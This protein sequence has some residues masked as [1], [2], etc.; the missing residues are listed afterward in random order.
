MRAVALSFVLALAQTGFAASPNPPPPASPIV[1]PEREGLELAT[2]LRST[3]P[4]ESSEFTGVLE[5]T[6]RDGSI[7]SVPVLSKLTV[8][9][10]NWLVVYQSGPTNQTPSETLTITHTPG[11]PNAYA[12]AIGTNPPASTGAITSPFGR[13]DFWLIDLGLDFLHW[14]KQRAIRAEMTRSRPCRVLESAH[15]NP[16]AGAYSRVLSWVDLETGGI[17]QAEAYDAQNKLLKK[18]AIGPVRKV[19]GQWQ[20]REMRIRNVQTRQQTELKFD[21]SGR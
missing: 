11:Q 18:F 1:D 17:I 14:P 3:V 2:R 10:T 9:P 16:V 7:R 19:G 13:S 20:L 6:S 21:L 12:L 4:A 5:V 8:T 15:P